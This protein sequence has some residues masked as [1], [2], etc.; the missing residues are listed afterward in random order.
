MIDRSTK[1]GNPYSIG[2]DGDRAEVIKK[3]RLWLWQQINLGEITKEELAELHGKRCGCWCKPKD[4]HGD[5]LQ[6][7]VLWAKQQIPLAP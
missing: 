2:K 1:F 7:A 4:C 5:V 6:S 3:Y